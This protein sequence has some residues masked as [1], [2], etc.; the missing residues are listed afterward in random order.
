MTLSVFAPYLA[1]SRALLVWYE[2]RLFFP[3]FQYFDMDTFGQEPPPDWQTGELEVEYYRLQREWKLERELFERERTRLEGDTA[4]VA[5]LDAQFSQ[6][7]QLRDHAAD[8]LESV[9]E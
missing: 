2:G 8:R 6:P 4:A 7:R 5:A 9:P 3:T 1:E